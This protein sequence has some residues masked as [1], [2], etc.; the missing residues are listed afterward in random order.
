MSGTAFGLSGNRSGS[1]LM[2]SKTVSTVAPRSNHRVRDLEKLLI[3]ESP[4][5][6]VLPMKVSARLMD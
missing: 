1:A 4:K 6:G 3:F 5:T 2:P